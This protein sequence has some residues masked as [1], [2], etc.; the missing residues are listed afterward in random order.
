[1]QILENAK[2]KF[3]VC[4]TMQEPQRTPAKKTVASV[5]FIKNFLLSF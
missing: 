2:P 4:G 1:M 5:T 3:K